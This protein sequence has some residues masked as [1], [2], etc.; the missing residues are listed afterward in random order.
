MSTTA[1]LWVFLRER[2]KFWLL[3]VFLVLTIFVAPIVLSLQ[4]K[5][6]RNGPYGCGL[7]ALPGWTTMRS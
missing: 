5:T 2:R 4:R 3:P 7:S 1:E 6:E